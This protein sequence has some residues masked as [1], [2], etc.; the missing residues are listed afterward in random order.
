[1]NNYSRLPGKEANTHSD[2]SH[3]S[4]ISEQFLPPNAGGGFEQLRDLFLT[5]MPHVTLH[6]DQLDQFV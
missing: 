5:P 3:G 4:P 6:A 1:M 2:V